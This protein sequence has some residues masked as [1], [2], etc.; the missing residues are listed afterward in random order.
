MQA[1]VH[2][3]CFASVNE[4][5][6]RVT[7]ASESERADRGNASA[8]PAVGAFSLEQKMRLPPQTRVVG[9]PGCPV[10]PGGGFPL[11][12]LDLWLGHLGLSWISLL[13]R[14]VGWGTLS[15]WERLVSKLAPM[16]GEPLTSLQA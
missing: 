8:D 13:Q 6:L 3:V 15:L 10:P 9:Q 2:R 14:T 1:K 12:Q 4:L 16:Q 7:I 11:L 5:C